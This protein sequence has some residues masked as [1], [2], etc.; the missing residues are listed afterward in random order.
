MHELSESWRG[1]PGNLF[2][3]WAPDQ[4]AAVGSEMFVK[5]SSSIYWVDVLHERKRSC[6]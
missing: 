2:R 3:N 6:Q 4:V 1:Y 5:E